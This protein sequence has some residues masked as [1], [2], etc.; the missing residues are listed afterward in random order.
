MDDPNATELDKMLRKVQALLAKADDPAVTPEES[1]SFRAGA[2]ALMVKYRIEESML[3][4]AAPVG[5]G[6]APVWKT[7]HICYF[8]NE[9]SQQY[10]TIASAVINHIGARAVFTTA[11]VR[12]EEGTA[13]T[14]W[15]AAEVVGYE[16]DLLYGEMLLTSAIM[17]FGHLLEPKYTGEESDQVNAYRMRKAGMEGRRIAM[18]LW[19]RDDKHLRPK[20]RKLYETEAIAR[21]ES[22]RHLMGQDVSVKTWRKSYADGFAD[23]LYWRLMRSKIEAPKGTELVLSGRVEAVSE[24]FYEK[25][26]RYRPAPD[27]A[28][29]IGT[30][31]DTC[32]KCA[33][34]KSGY[35]REHA[36]MKPSYS[37]GP[38]VNLT[39]RARGAEAASTV[40]LGTQERLS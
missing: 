39:A 40:D 30:G 16:S 23:E 2:E 34:A 20:A 31:H 29:T 25:Y 21:G 3:A 28:G 8:D 19:G 35:C 7:W 24:A 17:A 18:A 26:P 4:A 11:Y 38:K 12:N 33:K 10:R 22:P 6:L 14:M 32:K 1:Q 37:Q 15:W 9:F 27:P 5:T 36:W 13:S